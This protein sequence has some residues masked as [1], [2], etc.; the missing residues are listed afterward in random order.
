MLVKQRP[1]NRRGMLSLLSSDFEVYCSNYP[2]WQSL[3]AVALQEKLWMGWQRTP[4]H[5]AILDKVGSQNRRVLNS[6]LHQLKKK[7]V[8]LLGMLSV[9]STAPCGSWLLSRALDE[10]IL[11]QSVCLKTKGNILGRPVTK[12]CL[13]SL[14]CLNG[15]YA[16][17]LSVI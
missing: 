3:V 15:A 6:I 8:L 7:E 10:N 12:L 2:I 11:V 14:G 13:G 4:W 5:T 17:C 9:D 16:A 1:Y